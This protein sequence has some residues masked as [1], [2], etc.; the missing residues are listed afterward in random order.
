MYDLSFRGV[1]AWGWRMGMPLP[2][3]DAITIIAIEAADVLTF[4]EAP[5]PNVAAGMPPAVAA[6]LAEIAGL[7]DSPFVVR[8]SSVSVA[9]SSPCV[10][11]A[12]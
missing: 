1:L 3:D 7:P 6:V 5:T 4:G 11:T 9:E 12:P 10:T 8:S 2:A